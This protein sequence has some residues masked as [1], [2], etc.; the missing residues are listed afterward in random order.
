MAATVAHPGLGFGIFGFVVA[1][2]A[3]TTLALVALRALRRGA[4]PLATSICVAFAGI[5]LVES[6]GVRAQV[7]AWPLIALFL[8]LLDQEGPWIWALVPVAAVWSNLHAS[9]MLAPVLVGAATFGVALEERRVNARVGRYVALTAAVAVAICLNPLGSALPHYALTLFS[10]PIKHYISEWK[11]TD[12][13]DT[14]FAFGALPLLLGALV[15]GAGARERR[16]KDVIVFA[17]FA[18]LL[19]AAARNIAIF[20]LE[21]APLVA[22]GLTR[23]WPQHD[24]GEATP[25]DRTMDFVLPAFSFV[26]SLVVAVQLI[27]AIPSDAERGIPS[28]AL[29]ALDRAGTHRLFCSDFAWC[30]L[31]LPPTGGLPRQRTF[32]DGRADPFPSDV[33]KDYVAIVRVT[34]AWQQQ[35]DSHH[36]DAVLVSAGA[37][38][39]QA[40]ALVP[41]WRTSYRDKNFWL[42]LRSTRRS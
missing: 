10:N 42:Y 7:V 38:L 26:I 39:G 36:V 23:V 5:G 35:L 12:I 18:Y 17:A 34:P 21:A 6:F 41:G 11:V 8:F 2:C 13:G 14:S 24:Q 3:V 22:I 32:L 19:L 27:R 31:V 40:L 29:A 16:W 15:L 4:S 20:G 25:L 28:A 30:G 37:P 33:W 9:A 1:L